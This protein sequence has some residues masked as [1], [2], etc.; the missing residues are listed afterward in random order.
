MSYAQLQTDIADYL[1]RT[2][3]TADIPT[4]ISRAEAY[5]FRELQA[6]ELQLSVSGTTTGGYAALPAD[7]GSVSRVVIASDGRERS[8]DYQ[9]VPDA[10]TAIEAHPTKYCL[11]Q[12]QLRIWNA[13]DGQA[14]TLFYI[15]AFQAL[16]VSNTTNWLL[17][18]A[19]DLYLYASALEGARHIRNANEV[20]SLT[21]MMPTLLDSVKS[22]AERRGQPASGSLQIKPRR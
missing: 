1:H 12:N 2:D 3:L 18:N 20:A 4:F 8:L 14:Y 16:S 15:P 9:A 13:G 17:D 5:M 7:F 21:A 19:K 6:K 11:E 22:F 10:S